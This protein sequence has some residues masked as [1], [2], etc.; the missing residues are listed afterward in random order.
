MRF[1]D[2]YCPKTISNSDLLK[3]ANLSSIDKEEVVL[4]IDHVLRMH[5]ASTPKLTL[6]WTLDSNS[7]RG[8]PK[9]NWR[10]LVTKELQQQGL[11]WNTATKTA[12]DREQW[13]PL[14]KAFAGMHEMT[15]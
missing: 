2:I 5:L 6:R 14:V 10:R 13:K 11:E 8:R 7:K 4:V 12:E 1:Y 3:R 9:E 15:N